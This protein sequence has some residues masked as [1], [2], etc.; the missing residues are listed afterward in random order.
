MK[1]EYR[2]WFIGVIVL[3]VGILGG[4][5]VSKESLLR[6]G[7]TVKLELMPIDPRSLLQGDYMRL[8][9]RISTPPAGTV[10]DGVYRITLALSKDEDGIHQFKSVYKPEMALE[11]GDVRITGW[12][13]EDERLV[14]GIE[15]YFV[16]EN[17]GLEIQ[18]Q[19]KYG[20]VKLSRTG[21][22]ILIG[23]E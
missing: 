11:E 15:S 5:V 9:Y 21:D 18:R 14:F 4:L 10:P 6:A 19:A 12:V 1:P 7:Q 22:A 16:P 8:S 20:I 3:Q 23:V 17:T 2:K 13:H